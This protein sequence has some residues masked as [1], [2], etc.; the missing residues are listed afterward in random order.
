[1]RATANYLMA[2]SSP[3]APTRAEAL[4][5][6]E[7]L[8]DN[9]TDVA[10]FM[11]QVFTGLGGLFTEGFFDDVFTSAHVQMERAWSRKNRAFEAAAQANERIDAGEAKWLIERIRRDG[12]VNENEKALLSFLKAE[13]HSIDPSVKSLIDEVAA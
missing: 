6:Q 3:S 1:M 12:A 2:V 7:W 8:E 10:G 4:A 5:R 9:D 11:G 13:S